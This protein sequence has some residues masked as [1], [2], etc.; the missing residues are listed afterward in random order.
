[1]GILITMA[2]KNY[3]F[4]SFADAIYS[5]LT[6]SVPI[7]SQEK[8][9]GRDSQLEKIRLTLH[10]LGRH[11]FIYGDRG[12]GKTSLAHTAAYLIQSSDNR[13]ICISCE[14]SSTMESVVE[15]I[16]AQ[17][18][19]NMPM[20]H[21]KTT[22]TLGFNAFGVKAEVS[23]TNN[24]PQN[25]LNISNI[26]TAVAALRYLGENYS[27][28]SVIVIDEFDLISS[29]D[30]R[31]K[32]GIL[33]KQLSDGL[34]NVKII[35][36]G[37]G[38]SLTD[39]IGGHVSSMRQL[40]QVE[41]ERLN[42][43]GRES[44]ISS[45]FEKFNIIIPQDISYK[46]CALSDGFPYYVHLMCEKLLHE[47]FRA[48]FV[49]EE[50]T[51]EL[52]IKSLD[53]AV[54]SV[55]ETLKLSY[56]KA[57]ERDEHMH[58]ILWAMAESADL[59]RELEHIIDSYCVVI[60]N[61]GIQG[62]SENQFKKNFAKLRKESHGSIITHALKT[63]SGVRPGWFRFKESMIRGFVRMHAEKCGIELDFDR[64]Y[65]AL[66]ANVRT[67]SVRGYYAPLSTVEGKVARLRKD[68]EK[69]QEPNNKSN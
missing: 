5:I 12:V 63:K 37:I 16:I 47:C 34:V 62:L 65:S 2:I 58:Y 3:D 42:W 24:E 50:V 26:S 40:Q 8:L 54:Q 33:L 38:T 44:I 43:S 36:T 27:D 64:H 31:S 53:E 6:L 19:A 49:V 59:N 52:F 1:M 29:D 21:V 30:E 7:N 9:F 14:P 56:D 60:K 55:L 51:R 25:N 10:S 22:A 48:D 32:F 69:E 41:L 68:D 4:Q 23:R 15:S 46:I 39:L 57:T 45:A 66:S 28:V 61:L 67:A 13:P 20:E 11:V 35:F 17:A 18:K